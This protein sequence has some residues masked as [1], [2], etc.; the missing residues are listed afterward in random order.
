MYLG[1][2]DAINVEFIC[3]GMMHACSIFHPVRNLFHFR[4]YVPGV[5]EE[6]TSHNPTQVGLGGLC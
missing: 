5:L 2:D 3:D 1:G 6:K 4:Y